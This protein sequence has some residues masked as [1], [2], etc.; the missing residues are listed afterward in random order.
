[1]SKLNFADKN[2]CEAIDLLKQYPDAYAFMHCYTVYVNLIDDIIDLPELRTPTNILKLASTAS[3]LFSL[4]FWMQNSNQL[5]ILEQ[6]INNTYADSV[7][8]EKSALKWQRIDSNVLRHSGIDMLYAV[9]L[10]CYGYDKMREVSS[11]IREH[12]HLSHM[13]SEGKP[14]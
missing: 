10:I 4:P 14:I 2:I 5:L 12:C 8:W 7:E 11:K 6:C 9:I 3:M 1:M 13:D